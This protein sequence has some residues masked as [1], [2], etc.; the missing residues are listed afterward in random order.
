MIN[1]DHQSQIDLKAQHF[2][3]FFFATSENIATITITIFTAA[4]INHFSI[5]RSEK[6]TTTHFIIK[7][8]GKVKNLI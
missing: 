1:P 7:G 6:E 2:F 5:N 3:F 4:I 8:K